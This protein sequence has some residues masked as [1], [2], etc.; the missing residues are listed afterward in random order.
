MASLA[1]PCCEAWGVTRRDSAA[2]VLLA[3]EDPPG[4]GCQGGRAHL[5][6]APDLLVSCEQQLFLDHLFIKTFPPFPHLC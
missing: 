2:A 4:V 5:L 3:F 1:P 6:L